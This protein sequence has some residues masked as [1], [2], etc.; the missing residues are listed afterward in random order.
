[1]HIIITNI[2]D[3]HNYT[4]VVVRAVNMLGLLISDYFRSQVAVETHFTIVP[5][6]DSI[7]VCPAPL[8]QAS[9]VALVALDF[10][11]HITQAF[12]PAPF[13]L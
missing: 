6:A 11:G 12:R 1:M 13:S 2:G 5:L 3:L 10:C 8:T 9:P 4:V 7:C